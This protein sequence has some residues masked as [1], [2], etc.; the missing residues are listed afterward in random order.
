MDM[1]KISKLMMFMKE[2]VLLNIKMVIFMKVNLK[3]EK[4]MKE[5][6]LVNLHIGKFK[7]NK[8]EKVLKN[9]NF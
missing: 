3:M 5:F 2:K 9:N 6:M 7:N 4:E 1:F 8:I